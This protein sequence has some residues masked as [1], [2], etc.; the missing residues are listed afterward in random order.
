M[1]FIHPLPPH[2]SSLCRGCGCGRVFSGLFYKQKNWMFT[3]IN[4]HNSGRVNKHTWKVKWVINASIWTILYNAIPK[5]VLWN[6][7]HLEGNVIG[8]GVG[9]WLLW[10]NETLYAELKLQKKKKKKTWLVNQGVW[11]TYISNQIKSSEVMGLLFGF[12]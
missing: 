1:D 2:P 4:P 12:W 8:C 5:R 11:C 7:A 6:I 3:N 10:W 9:R